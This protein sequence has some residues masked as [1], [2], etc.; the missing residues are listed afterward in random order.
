LEAQLPED[1][2]VFHGE[3]RRERSGNGEVNE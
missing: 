2:R 1:L 3:S